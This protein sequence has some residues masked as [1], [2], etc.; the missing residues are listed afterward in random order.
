MKYASGFG[1]LVDS[2]TGEVIKKPQEL[3]VRIGD[4]VEIGANTCVDR[5]SWRD[6][7]IGNSVKIDNLV[8]VRCRTFPNL[9]DTTII[10]ESPK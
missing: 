6:T 5:G 7:V 3:S 2:N 10:G 8:Q 1:F 4:D 9:C